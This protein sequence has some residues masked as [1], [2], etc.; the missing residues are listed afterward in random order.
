MSQRLIIALL[1]LGLVCP[2][3]ALADSYVGK[4]LDENGSPLAGAVVRIINDNNAT[5]TDIDGKFV[6]SQI[7][8]KA[9]KVQV[10]YVGFVTDTY[11]LKSTNSD[12]EQLIRLTP[13]PNTLNEVG[14]DCNTH[15]QD[16]KGCSRGDSSC[17]GGRYQ[18]D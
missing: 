8:G 11:I 1:L 4:V 15:S 3:T 18:K 16:L 10:S 7:N 6:L 14:C 5:V 17:F 2:Y 13:D 9:I 12:K